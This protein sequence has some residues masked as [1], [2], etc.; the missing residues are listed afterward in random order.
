MFLVSAEMFVI[1]IKIFF[2]LLPF[3]AASLSN[4]DLNVFVD[5]ISLKEILLS[6]NLS[7]SMTLY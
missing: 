5:D 1:C 3:C 6:I 7:Y 2:C 4:P